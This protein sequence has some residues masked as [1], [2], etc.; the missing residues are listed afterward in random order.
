MQLSDLVHRPVLPIPWQEGDNI[1]WHDPDFSARMLAEHL[2]QAH[3]AASRRTAKII[4]HVDWIHNNVLTGR[5]TK[6]LD[7]GCGPGLYSS[8]LAKLGHQCVGI[9]YSPASIRYAVEDA[10][11]EHLNC[12]YHH[13]DIR[14]ADYGT[15]YGLVMLIFGEFNVFRPADAR[16]ILQKARAALADGGLLL[17]EPHSYEA[18]RE[19]G[20]ESAS[21]YTGGQGLFSPR[22]HLCLTEHFWHEKYHCNTTRHF[23]VDA[24]SGEI[25]RYA[26]SM[27]AY[28][29]T[30]YQAVLTECGFSNIS[31]YPSLIG[32]EDPNQR[33][34]I[35]ITAR[36]NAGSNGA[37]PQK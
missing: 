1:P 19:I 5:P 33:Y 11:K 30:Q 23:V 22:P 14:K 32:V 31:F 36:K 13:E 6:I 18:I 12:V 10:D 17:L 25:A 34:L 28:T 20:E 29:E 35:A 8:R 9:D 27:Q 2:T 21:W 7:L 24:A 37:D 26:Q 4:L 16:L 15:G 3:D